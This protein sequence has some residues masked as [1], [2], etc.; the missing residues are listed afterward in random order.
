M[1]S[2]ELIFSTSKAKPKAKKKTKAKIKQEHH[3][4]LVI[5]RL[6]QTTKNFMSLHVIC[7]CTNI[8]V[9][10]KQHK[11]RTIQFYLRKNYS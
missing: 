5:N 3:F 9:D 4:S 8:I 1:R 7:V 11:L 2:A 10:L 6:K